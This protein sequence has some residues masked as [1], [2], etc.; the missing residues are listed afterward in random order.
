[1]PITNR[2]IIYLISI[3]VLFSINCSK[4]KHLP[5]PIL[6][7]EYETDFETF[8]KISDYSKGV[9]G[10]Q[11]VAAPSALCNK[12][13]NDS[14]LLCFFSGLKDSDNNPSVNITICKYFHQ[15]QLNTD[16]N[17]CLF[18]KNENDFYDVFKKGKINII[19]LDSSDRHP[20]GIDIGIST[21]TGSY[22]FQ[23]SFFYNL[24]IPFPAY[25]DT[26]NSF[27]IIDASK[28]Y[29][30]LQILS[31]NNAINV[32]ARK[33]LVSLKFRCK[34]YDI[35]APHDSFMVKRGVFQGIFVDKN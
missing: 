12:S 20:E 10:N 26:S 3:L 2:I 27:E 35:T 7:L 22:I 19:N 6:I 28:E 32:S 14:I 17:G 8:S 23:N 29:N 16:E 5:S 4:K 11:L 1:M 9:T 13:N 21:T 30:W 24:T 18:P 25:L 34:L 15:D 33:I 31:V